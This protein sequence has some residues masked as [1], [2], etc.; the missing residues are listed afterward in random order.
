MLKGSVLEAAFYRFLS[1]YLVPFCV[2]FRL[3]ANHISFFSLLCGLAAGISFIFSPFWGGLL[4]LITG[5]LD[6]LDGALARELK[7]EKAGHP[8]PMASR[9][10]TYGARCSLARA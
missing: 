6:T 2:F 3:K 10:T 8:T 4:T 1:R 9:L 7:Q 5:L